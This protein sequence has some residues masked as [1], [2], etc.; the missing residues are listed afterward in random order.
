MMSNSLRG[1]Q[2]ARNVRLYSINL[3]AREKYNKI[4]WR[5]SGLDSAHSSTLESEPSPTVK[6]NKVQVLM[7]VNK[8]AKKHP[9]VDGNLEETDV[10]L[11]K[12]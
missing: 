8:T 7:K 12:S 10:T 2:D 1:E 4:K 3:K 6:W 9:H 5:K 11:D